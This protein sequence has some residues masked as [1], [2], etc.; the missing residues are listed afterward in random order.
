MYEINFQPEYMKNKKIRK[1]LLLKKFIALGVALVIIITGFYLPS[2][3]LNQLIVRKDILQKQHPITQNRKASSELQ[4][5]KRIKLLNSINGQK[6]K[7]ADN[8]KDIKNYLTGEIVIGNI[9]N[10]NNG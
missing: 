4:F 7:I 8:I 6:Q 3:I 10:D 9:K 5:Q 1:N 2:K